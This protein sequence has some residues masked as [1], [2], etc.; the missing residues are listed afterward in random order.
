M[1]NGRNLEP[2]GDDDDDDND[3]DNNNKSCSIH[4]IYVTTE[5]TTFHYFVDEGN[6]EPRVFHKT[7]TK[8]LTCFTL[9]LKLG[10]FCDAAVK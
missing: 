5:Y 9:M 3:D 1:L 10:Y 6:S 4:K 2:Y 8:K 7:K